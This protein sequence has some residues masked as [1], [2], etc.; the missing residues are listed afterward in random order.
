MAAETSRFAVEQKTGGVVPGHEF[1]E[2]LDMAM[3]GG[4]HAVLVGGAT[5]IRG[6]GEVVDA[7]LD[8]GSKRFGEVAPGE[9][10]G[11][12]FHGGGGGDVEGTA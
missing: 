11:H 5:E 9:R 12:G 2:E 4:E 1:A 3:T 7:A 6:L 8:A 10:A